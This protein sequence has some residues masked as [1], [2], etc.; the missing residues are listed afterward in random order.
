MIWKAKLRRYLPQALACNRHFTFP[1]FQQVPKM[2]P[3]DN[4]AKT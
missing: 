2:V 3:G 4:E 1:K